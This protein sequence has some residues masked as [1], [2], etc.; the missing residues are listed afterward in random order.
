MPHFVVHCSENVLAV[1]PVDEMM[2]AVHDTAEATGLFRPG[3]IK[4][5]VQGFTHYNV[6]NTSNDFIHVFGNI[7]GGRTIEQRASLSRAV[8]SKLTAMYPE[9]P[10][11]SMNVFEFEKATYCNRTML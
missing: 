3:D 11:I 5:R 4:V 9:V 2:R 10:V 7:M 1:R 6:A 8:I